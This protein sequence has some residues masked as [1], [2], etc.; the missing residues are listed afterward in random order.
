MGPHPKGVKAILLM[1]GEGL[2]FGSSTFKQFHRI[3]G[4][5]IYLLTL[6]QF[7]QTRLFEEIILVCHPK[8]IDEVKQD[9]TAYSSDHIKI[10][11]GGSSRQES[12]YLGVLACGSSTKHVVIHDAVRPFVSQEIIYNNIKGAIEFGAVDTCIPSADTLVYAPIN[13]KIQKIPK[14]SEYLR[15]QTPQSFAYPLIL[16]A[17]KR[18][19]ELNLVESSDDCQLVLDMGIDVHVVKGDERNIKITSELDLF[20]A[21]Q[22]LRL[23][24][25]FFSKTS[26]PLKNK[27]FIITGGTGGIG[28]EISQLLLQEGAI[29]LT[30]ARNSA[31]YSADL[32]SYTEAINAFSKIKAEYGPV[33]GL[34]NCIGQFKVK[35]INDLTSQEILELISA[36]LTGLIFSCKCAEIKEGG[37][38]INIA[39][40]CYSKGRKDY[41]TYSSAKAAVVNFTQGFAEER[42]HLKINALVPQRTATKMRHEQFPY[43]DPKTL[44]SPNEVA[45]AAIELLQES[46]MTGSIMEVRKR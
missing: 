2:R 45:K 11:C 28:K 44:L 6:E 29:P 7:L 30:I 16:K 32:T 22:L 14:R 43:E 10:I 39:S 27:R 12:S 4:K 20:I 5:K 34:I 26:L 21:E 36:N 46:E 31:S 41:A 42:P 18:A 8:G 37:H 38:I 23:P 3:S 24:V 17:H 9:L 35:T 13:D 15:G 40:S 25:P 33:D 1:A 19:L